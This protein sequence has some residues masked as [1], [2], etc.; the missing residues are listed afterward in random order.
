MKLTFTLL[1]FVLS[2]TVLSQSLETAIKNILSD[3]TNNTGVSVMNSKGELVANIN[4]N[5]KKV[6]QSVFKFHLALAILDKVDK[7]ELKL[8]QK[9]KL[10]PQDYIN[11]AYSP[12]ALKNPD[13]KEAVS[14]GDL[15]IYSAGQSD[16]VACEA[17]F[18]I[19][20]GPQVLNQYLKNKE[21]K[22]IQ[23]LHTE[24]GM[25]EKWEAQF[26]NWSTAVSSVELLYKFENNQ[27][28]L[29]PSTDYLRQILI[30][31]PTGPNRLKGGLPSIIKV[32]HKT[33]TSGVKTGITTAVNDI[34]IVYLPNG[35]PYYISVFVSDS[36]Y[37]MSKTEEIIARVSKTVFEHFS[38]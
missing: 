15:I 20:G 25:F 32:A 18:R 13:G 5:E 11:G 23:I 26:D 16:N 4:G 21:I 1:L 33:G 12:L 35:S 22:G 37:D 28:V 10:Q 36:P 19:L 38:K 6:L 34:G 9:F 30:S 27:M 24:R 17:L 3:Y 7:G 2:R 14:L 8:S 29:K 31:S